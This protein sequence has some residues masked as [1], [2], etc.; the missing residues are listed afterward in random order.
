MLA[1]LLESAE[2]L[3]RR[4]TLLE[5]FLKKHAGMEGRTSAEERILQQCVE[6]LRE[7]SQQMAAVEK[8]RLAEEAIRSLLDNL[9][10]A[11]DERVGAAARILDRYPDPKVRSRLSAS[12]VAW[13]DEHLPAKAIEEHDLL[14]EAENSD[15][16]IIRGFFKKVEDPDG[17]LVGYKR[18]TTYEQ[19][20]SPT[21]EVGT[22]RVE[23][24]PV[25]PDNSELRRCVEAY[26]DAR[27]KLL[28]HLGEPE[29]WAA[30]ATV[31]DTSEVRLEA[32]RRK[33]GSSREALSFAREASF[34]RSV[35]E[36]PAIT[37]L[38]ALFGQ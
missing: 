30:L 7:V 8:D 12:A 2:D 15:G 14:R 5:S 22:F 6:Q 24:L 34:A 37:S 32:Y 35:V 23:Q 27:S 3:S 36:G 20:V 9:P 31:C 29:R 13:L 26:N 28:D 18:Y 25:L 11:Y 1:G 21:A 19:F 38:Q 10:E 33:P 16:Q 17:T 4:K